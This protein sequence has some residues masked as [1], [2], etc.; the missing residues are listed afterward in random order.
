MKDG[1]MKQLMKWTL[2]LAVSTLILNSS[3]AWNI[4]AKGR[5]VG[6]VI[7]TTYFLTSNNASFP[8][9]AMAYVGSY[10]NGTCNYNATYNI[11]SDHLQTGDFV[12]IDGFML[13]S[14]VGGGYSCMTIFYTNKQVV[15]ETFQLFYDGINYNTSNPSTAEVT[16]L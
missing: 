6:P 7:H 13:K 8:V 5:V 3:Y 1:V 11:G 10:V 14:V 15:M 4:G 16:I 2:I 9:K 12:D